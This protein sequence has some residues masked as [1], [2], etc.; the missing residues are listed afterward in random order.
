MQER[1][2]KRVLEKERKIFLVWARFASR[3]RRVRELRVARQR[4]FTRRVLEAWRNEAVR[5][6]RM[7]QLLLR[8]GTHW[9]VGDCHAIALVIGALIVV[10]QIVTKSLVKNEDA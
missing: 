10:I 2:S 8:C 5:R 3:D 6:R 7:R 1:V 9:L 4:S